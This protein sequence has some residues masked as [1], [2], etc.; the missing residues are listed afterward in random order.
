MGKNSSTAQYLLLCC[1]GAGISKVRAANTSIVAVL[2]LSEAQREHQ[3]EESLN[4]NS[5]APW[6][7]NMVHQHFCLRQ[8]VF[9]GSHFLNRAMII[10]YCQKGQ[11]INHAW[12]VEFLEGEK[13]FSLPFQL[14][15][16]HLTN[17]VSGQSLHSNRASTN[18]ACGML[19]LH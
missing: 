15:A 14:V 2:K 8:C 13:N 18:K 10:H 5:S 3:T 11:L 9:F 19:F 6:L 12:Q 7:K 4:A 16:S 17:H 1:C